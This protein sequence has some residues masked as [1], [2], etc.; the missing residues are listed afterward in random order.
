[1]DQQLLDRLRR[2]REAHVAL[3]AELSASQRELRDA[4]REASGLR[5]QLARERQRRVATRSVRIPIGS[6]G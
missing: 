2:L 1:M 5:A 3:A 4:R 6:R